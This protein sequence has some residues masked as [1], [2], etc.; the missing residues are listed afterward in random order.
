MIYTARTPWILN[1]GVAMVA[2]ILAK[3][4]LFVGHLIES[5]D[6][7]RRTSARV[8]FRGAADAGGTVMGAG[9]RSGP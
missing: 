9:S 5:L 3:S 8:A 2:L 7:M 4:G 1:M 6:L